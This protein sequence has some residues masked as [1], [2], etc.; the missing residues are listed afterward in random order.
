MPA[1]RAHHTVSYV[2]SNGL[3]VLCGGHDASRMC[4]DVWVYHIETGF[5]RGFVVREFFV[6]AF[7]I[8]IPLINVILFGL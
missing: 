8:C 2:E 3:V 6:V 5:V 1:A 4:S 7:V